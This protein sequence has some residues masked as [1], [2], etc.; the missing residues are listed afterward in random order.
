MSLAT[1]KHNELAKRI[2]Y[3]QLDAQTCE[4]LRFL[5]PYVDK[6]LPA[7]LSS[8]YQKELSNPELSAKFSSP[9]RVEM[10]KRAQIRHWNLFFD[11]RFDEDYRSSIERISAAHYR[12]GLTPQWYMAGYSLILDCIQKMV[13]TT[14]SSYVGTRSSN[15]A[16]S[17]YVQSVNRAVI[18]DMELA[19]TCYW[20]LL[21]K[22]RD[23][24]IDA[25]VDKI[26]LQV[27]DSLG[28]ISNVM[29]D[30]VR[31]AELMTCIN[32][33]IDFSSGSAS[34]AAKT[35]LGSAETVAAAA[36]EL[37]AS[38]DEI[39]TQV[40]RSAATA[41]SAVG[42]ASEAGNVVTR[43][44]AAANEIGKV[45]KIIGKIAAQTNLLALNATI[46][47]ARAGDAGKGFSVVAGEV[48]ILARQ[49]GGAAKEIGAQICKIQE[50]SSLTERAMCGVSEHI[51]NIEHISAAIA[52]AI[53]EQTAA[54]SEIAR[55]VNE[56]ASQC[57]TVTSAMADVSQNV[58]KASRA[59]AAVCEST[60]RMTESLV[61]MRKLLIKAIRTSSTIADRRGHRRRAVLLEVN[62]AF[63][64]EQTKGKIYDIS[65][66]GGMVQTEATISLG[67]SVIMSNSKEGLLLKA[68]VIAIEQGRLHLQFNDGLLA[69]YVSDL[70]A[71]SLINICEI[72]K[73][74]HIIFVNMV[75]DGVNSGALQASSLTNHHTCRLGFWYDSVSDEVLL[76]M[77]AFIALDTPHK[78]IHELAY[79]AI[80]AVEADGN[81]LSQT[82]IEEIRATSKEVISRL[83]Q[84]RAD[85]EV[86][87]GL[88]LCI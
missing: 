17:G 6:A 87:N 53:E 36:E 5:K 50:A 82:R 4:R 43:L 71:R 48:K 77:P 13:I 88:S 42:R 74:D 39:A 85:Y 55:A 40:Q 56:S 44:G 41:Q 10:A 35:A 9:D 18:L 23:N 21:T 27:A 28:G 60:T 86:N 72:A 52:A 25:M 67:A 33:T 49:S 80:L 73:S 29:D 2:Q 12:I 16:L 32:M 45:V 31:N 11:A 62:L 14:F 20:E 76:G 75:V 26:E 61:A 70:A 30:L 47:A 64:Q 1:M 84:L 3:M 66:L 83:D 57:A 38:I 81:S 78:E 69:E 7:M 58:V 63:G 15:K 8:F 46:E 22:E 68:T 24:A 54:T 51:L 59:T 19:I 79:K 37:H 65:E 34:D